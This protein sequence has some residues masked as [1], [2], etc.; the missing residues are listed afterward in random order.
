MKYNERIKA[1]R[2]DSDKKQIELA[3]ILETSQSY[4]SE[5]ELGKRL[6][7]IT[8]LRTLCIFYNVS[9]DY[10]LGLP[11]GMAHYQNNKGPLKERIYKETVTDI[12]LH[13]QEQGHIRGDIELLLQNIWSH[14]EEEDQL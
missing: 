9:A 8:K 4:Y 7:P 11:A 6:L 1:L 12:I 10:I 2:E 3:K 5:Y 14:T 13:A